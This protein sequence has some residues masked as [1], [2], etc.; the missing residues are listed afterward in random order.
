M[1]QRA[2][3]IVIGRVSGVANEASAGQASTLFTV[4][5][6]RTLKG[7]S[8]AQ[9]TVRVAGGTV[10]GQ[11]QT[12]EDSAHFAVGELVLVFLEPDVDGFRVVGGFQGKFSIDDRGRI[13]NEP[14]DQFVRRVQNAL[15]LQ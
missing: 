10:G 7:T 6:E 4:A 12:V 14:V 13:G 5:V 8:A 2:A 9:V 1:T 11:T 15:V 3:L